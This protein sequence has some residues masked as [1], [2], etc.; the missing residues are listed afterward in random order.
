MAALSLSD[1]IRA[2][3]LEEL[4]EKRCIVVRGQRHPIAVFFH[5]DKVFACDN[6]CPHLGFPLSKG[7]LHNGI[8]TCDWHHARFDLSSGCTFDLFADDVPT[9]PVEVRGGQVFVSP[10]C[11]TPDPRER[12]A[13]SGI[14]F[15]PDNRPRSMFVR[16]SDVSPIGIVFEHPAIR[17]VR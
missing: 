5:A 1:W 9:A 15:A 16:E 12:V 4:K 8:L 2:G 10:L 14:Y 7:S 3:T 11:R 17:I 13:S 6:R